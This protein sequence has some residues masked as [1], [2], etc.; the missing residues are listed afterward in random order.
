[1]IRPDISG[2]AGRLRRGPLAPGQK[3]ADHAA[4]LRP[5]DGPLMSLRSQPR[6]G[7]TC[8]S[9]YC[10]LT[11]N[12]FSGGGRYIMVNRCSRPIPQGEIRELNP[13]SDKQELLRV[14]GRPATMR[15][16]SRSVCPLA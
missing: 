10:H 13:Y 9:N 8:S 3:E 12:T 1:M 15:D 2:L 6:P 7:P 11:V 14:T 5:P 16:A 4:A